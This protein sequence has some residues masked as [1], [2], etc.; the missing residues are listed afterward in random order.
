MLM[1]CIAYLKSWLVQTNCLISVYLCC[2]S[3]GVGRTGTYI[4]IDY[5]IQQARAEGSIDVMTLVHQMRTQRVNMVQ[6]R[7]GLTTVYITV[8]IV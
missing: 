8:N 4:A 2:F 6:T 1:L 5:L 3:A 7:V